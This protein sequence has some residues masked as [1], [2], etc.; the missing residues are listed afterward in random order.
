MNRDS[1][2][3][4]QHHLPYL[5][6]LMTNLQSQ[7]LMWLHEEDALGG[8]TVMEKGFKETQ[9]ICDELYILKD[10]TVTTYN[11]HENN[12]GGTCCIHD[13]KGKG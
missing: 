9:K 2:Y 4:L 7:C 6:S 10:R 13:I 12:Y 1:I 11:V 3:M 5:M 8:I